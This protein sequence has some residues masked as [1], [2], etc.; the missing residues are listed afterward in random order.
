MRPD[1]EIT[2]TIVNRINEFPGLAMIGKTIDDE[3]RKA[4]IPEEQIGTAATAML[5]LSG[6]L[7]TLA[8]IQTLPSV[9]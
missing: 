5:M 3:M 4:G 8:D 2:S 9:E 1:D 6:V 7:L